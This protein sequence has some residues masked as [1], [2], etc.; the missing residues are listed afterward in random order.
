MTSVGTLIELADRIEAATGP[1]QHLDAVIGHAI[2]GLHILPLR[3]TA[4][5]DAAMS[6]T[7][8]LDRI[9]GAGPG[10]MR[11]A[12]GRLSQRFALHIALW[13]EDHSYTEWLAR[14]VAAA[15]LR[16]RAVGGAA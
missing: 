8:G 9:I 15:A 1:D 3:Y 2:G 13:P 14:Y 7:T 5:L 6:L 12:M 16:A 10:L 11:E 4:S